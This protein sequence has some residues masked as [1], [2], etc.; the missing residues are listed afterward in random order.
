MVIFHNHVFQKNNLI[1]ENKKQWSSS[2]PRSFSIVSVHFV[3]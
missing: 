1:K 3:I 2:Q